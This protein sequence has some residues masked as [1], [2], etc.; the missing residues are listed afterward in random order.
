M[1]A[2]AEGGAA[3]V[4]QGDV[5]SSWS[6]RTSG[7]TR[8]KPPSPR[9]PNIPCVRGLTEGR[10]AKDHARRQAVSLEEPAPRHM[11]RPPREN[12]FAMYRQE[13]IQEP[14][15]ETRITII[16]LAV[17]LAMLAALLPDRGGSRKTAPAEV[18]QVQEIEAATVE[19]SDNFAQLD[20]IYE[21]LEAQ[22]TA[23]SRPAVKE[24]NRQLI[25][26]FSDCIGIFG[27]MF[28][29]EQQARNP[30]IR[31]AAGEVAGQASECMEAASDMILTA[32]RLHVAA[33]RRTPSDDLQSG[34]TQEE[35][36]QGRAGAEAGTEKEVTVRLHD[37]SPTSKSVSDEGDEKFSCFVTKSDPIPAGYPYWDWYTFDV[38]SAPPEIETTYTCPID[39]F[40]QHLQYQHDIMIPLIHLELALESAIMDG[41]SVTE[42]EQTRLD[43][44]R[45]EERQLRDRLDRIQCRSDRG[46]SIEIWPWVKAPV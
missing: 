45:Q 33:G 11:A 35:T 32:S 16:E 1:A 6:L 43:S 2:P 30:E 21:K 26:I 17:L 20:I 27:D 22:Q 5:P 34:S 28:T 7:R 24:L 39:G 13:L 40:D 25:E 10:A 37:C 18:M 23:P 38:F 4:R 36:P 31:T 12:D 19:L 44:L 14:S 42:L 29:I 41:R 8:K 3:D 9:N 46:S 15:K